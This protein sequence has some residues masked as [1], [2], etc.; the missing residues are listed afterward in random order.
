MME[1]VS[2]LSSDSDLGS[3]DSRGLG[4]SLSD[5]E[6]GRGVREESAKQ[7]CS[8][9]MVKRW[10]ELLWERSGDLRAEPPTNPGGCAVL[11]DGN[12]ISTTGSGA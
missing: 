10:S 2:V 6:S 3:P 1:N 11:H 7:D 5:T 4:L 8:A 9:A 12:P